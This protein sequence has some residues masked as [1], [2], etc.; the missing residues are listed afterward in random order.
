MKTALI[1]FLCLLATV[2]QVFLV[3]LLPNRIKNQWLSLLAVIGG[4]AASFVFLLLIALLG[5]SFGML[6]ETKT[7][8]TVVFSLVCFVDTVCLYLERCRKK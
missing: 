1:L 8:L 2:M 6:D 5:R 7:Y 3:I 4:F